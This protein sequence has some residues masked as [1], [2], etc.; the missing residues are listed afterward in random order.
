MEYEEQEETYQD[1]TIKYST[2][3]NM[4]GVKR[5]FCNNQHDEFITELEKVKYQYYSATYK[6]WDDF[7]GRPDFVA[8]NL[9]KGF[10]QSFGDNRK[11]YFTCFR[12]VETDNK[13]YTFESFWIVNSSEF[14][15]ILGSSYDDYDWTEMDQ[16]IFLEKFK[17]QDNENV[18]SE[19]YV[20]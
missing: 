15:T 6:Y 19:D 3:G 14:K 1:A 5:A 16:T 17:K 12:C 9:N 2:F 8:R 11:Y 4:E 18:I 10:I 20:H 13:V 7:T